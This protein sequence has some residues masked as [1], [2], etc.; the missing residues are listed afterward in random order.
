MPKTI[1]IPDEVREVLARSEI[2]DT[3]LTLPQQLD[4]KLYV[5]TNKIIEAAG[6]K[7]NRS[8][9][10]YVFSFDPRAALG[11]A[12]E[13][14]EIINQQQTFQEFWTP[15]WLADRMCRDLSPGARVLEP[16]A[17]IG[18]IAKAAA[19]AGAYVVCCELQ[20][21]LVNL[22]R[23]DSRLAVRPAGDFL[24]LTADFLQPFDFVLMNPPFSNCQDIAHVRHAFDFLRPGGVLRAIMSPGLNFR[25]DRKTAEFKHWLLNSRE[26]FSAQWSELDSATF[27]ESG[28]DVATIFVEVYKA[29]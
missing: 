10:C 23:E 16:S 18:R 2:T 8:R 17:G 3:T 14:G 28:T 12:V 4:R 22:L 26:V 15:V 6:G 25:G 13:S 29:A 19:S 5:Q 9:A 24:Q 1:T 27:R 11:L 20:E 21:K 7:W